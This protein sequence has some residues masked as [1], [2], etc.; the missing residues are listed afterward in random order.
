LRLIADENIPRVAVDALRSAGHDVVSI[1]EADAG[2]SDAEIL[3]LASA[4]DRVLVTFDRD[5]GELVYRAGR[6][7]SAGVVL[8]R[9]A[10]RS[11]DGTSRLLR[12]LISTHESAL[13]GAFT[14][15]SEA[16]FR[17]RALPR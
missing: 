12:D 16:G 7:A 13:R 5:F 6:D 8:C 14:V 15:V 9:F 1:A 3:V 17:R 2:L 10:Q 11:P 4:T